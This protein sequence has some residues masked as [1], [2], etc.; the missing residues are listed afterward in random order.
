MN[1]NPSAVPS[2]LA[3]QKYYA[4]QSELCRGL[5]LKTFFETGVRAPQNIKPIP[6]PAANNIASHDKVECSAL[7]PSPPRRTLPKGDTT[8]A[9]QNS[10]NMFADH[11]KKASK[12][13]II[14]PFKPPC[15]ALACVPPF[16]YSA[17]KIGGYAKGYKLFAI[18]N[19][20]HSYDFRHE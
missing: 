9:R 17:F 20:Y 4:E 3:W 16:D 12:E 8:S 10:T 5:H 1:E 14:S 7:A 18:N 13:P 2:P 6:I 19:E 15:A 11:I